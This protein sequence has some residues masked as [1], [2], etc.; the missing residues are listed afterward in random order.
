M[1][2]DFVIL[3]PVTNT[4]LPLGGVWVAEAENLCKRGQQHGDGRQKHG[5]ECCQSRTEAR[6]RLES[7]GVARRGNRSRGSILGTLWRE[8]EQGEAHFAKVLRKCADSEDGCQG[9]SS[10]VFAILR[11]LRAVA[12][13]KCHGGQHAGLLV[14]P[15]ESRWR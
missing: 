13:A 11:L 2:N 12:V 9:L 7:C 8:V 4:V 5:K 6:V 15:R 14:V 10:L 3:P 1:C